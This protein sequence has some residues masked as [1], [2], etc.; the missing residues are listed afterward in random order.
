MNESYDVKGPVARIEQRRPCLA[1]LEHLP[2]HENFDVDLSSFGKLIQLTNYTCGQA[3]RS[4]ERFFYDDSGKQIRSVTFDN[5]GNQTS[6]TEYDYSADGLCVGWVI[7]DILGTAM[8]RGVQEY[9]GGLL[10]CRTVFRVNN[11]M[12]VQKRFEY[13]EGKLR[14]SHAT[15]YGPSGEATEQWFSAYDH[16]GRIAETFGRKPDGSPLGDGRYTH[17]Y[18]SEGW[19]TRVLSFNDAGNE[20]VPNHVSQF[21]YACDERGNWLE[22]REYRRFRGD[23]R[24]RERVTT[25]KIT[26]RDA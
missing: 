16:A 23:S 26:Y 14:N 20:A 7:R 8:G 17:E 13:T 10:A 9:V 5:A 19:R 15:Y 4:C 2:G 18:N 21:V 24:W 25:R 6:S 11:L 22:R 1:R 3:V 12:T